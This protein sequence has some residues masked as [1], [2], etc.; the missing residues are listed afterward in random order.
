MS[1]VI[2]TVK[3]DLKH[4]NRPV[5]RCLHKGKGFKVLVVGMYKGMSMHDHKTNVS[6]TLTVLEGS[7]Y[8]NNGHSSTL[9]Q[10]YEDFAIPTAE[11]HSI[12]SV[13]DCLFLLTQGK[14]IQAWEA[15]DDELT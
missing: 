4:S 5:A 14:K 6:T 13:D 9:L 10:Q 15:A 7:L 2:K 12:E 8:Y 3:A 11:M 1:D